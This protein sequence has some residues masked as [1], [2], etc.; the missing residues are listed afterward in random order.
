MTRKIPVVGFIPT[1]PNYSGAVILGPCADNPTGDWTK[2]FVPGTT[3]DVV[4]K[5]TKRLTF[6]VKNPD[7]WNDP[8][9][10]FRD[11]KTTVKVAQFVK[12]VSD[13]TLVATNVSTFCLTISGQDSV[14]IEP[15]Q[16][17]QDTPLTLF[18]SNTPG[19]GEMMLQ[20]FVDITQNFAL[21]IPPNKPLLGM[22]WNDTST[23]TFK[24]WNGKEWKI[25][26]EHLF[27]PAQPFKHEQ[28]NEQ[29]SWTIKHNLSVEK[30]FIVNASFF[31][32]TPK[33]IKPILPSDVEYVDANTIN[34]SFSNAYSG[35]ALIRP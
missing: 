34:V 13:D 7:G 15:G 3:F 28:K 32:N 16:E 9:A 17:N 35:Y 11:G 29:F 19:W 33:G 6:S 18:G 8:S 22:I 30:P 23:G 5:N 12:D 26:N 31:V 1:V 24:T 14:I 4:G 20:N 10:T 25:V 21:A 2:V 27:A